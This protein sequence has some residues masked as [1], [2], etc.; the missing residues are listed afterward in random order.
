MGASKDK[1]VRVDVD[2]NGDGKIDYFIESDAKITADE[3]SGKSP[4]PKP[5]DSNATVYYAIGAVA[6]AG[7]AAGVAYTLHKRRK[8]KII[9]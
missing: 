2:N 4:P 9:K 8:Q 1:R 5:S 7:A 3:F 6:G